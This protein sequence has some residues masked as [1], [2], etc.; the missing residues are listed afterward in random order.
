MNPKYVAQ[1]GGKGSGNMIK[2]EFLVQQGVGGLRKLSATHWEPIQ[3][4]SFQILVLR[5]TSVVLRYSNKGNLFEA[6]L[7]ILLKKLMVSDRILIYD[8]YATDVGS[9][10]VYLSP[11]EYKIE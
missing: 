2:G 3:V 4:D 5:D 9:I 8:I 6:K 11:L 1:V 10:K 7:K